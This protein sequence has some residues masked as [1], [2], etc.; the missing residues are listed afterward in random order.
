MALGDSTVSGVC[1]FFWCQANPAVLWTCLPRDVEK[2]S[3]FSFCSYPE[4]LG[5]GAPGRRGGSVERCMEVE[6]LLWQLRAVLGGTLV[7]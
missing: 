7:V 5:G 3:M 2:S 6:M 4:S 1:V